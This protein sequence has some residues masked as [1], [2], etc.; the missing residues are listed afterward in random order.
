MSGIAIVISIRIIY[1]IEMVRWIGRTR[2]KELDHE[3]WGSLICQH[4]ERL[5][6]YNLLEDGIVI[7]IC[8][9]SETLLQNQ[10]NGTSING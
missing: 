5:Q 7:R 2:W 10:T 9:L 4:L 1:D 8:D 3:L 6:S